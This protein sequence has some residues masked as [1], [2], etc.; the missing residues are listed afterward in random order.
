MELGR[1]E[2]IERILEGAESA[3]RSRLLESEVYGIV[4]EVG[5][6][7]PAFATVPAGAPSAEI[8]A[9]AAGLLASCRPEGLVIKIESPDILHKTEAGGLLFAPPD[10]GEAARRCAALTEA[11]LR[12]APKARLAGLL[13]CEKIPY[14]PD[15][16]GLE[17]LLSLRQDRAL[18]PVV[19]VGLGGL[20]TE[21]YGALA[22]GE[23]TWILSA[24]DP[25]LAADAPPPEGDLSPAFDLL[26][27]PSRVH[28]KAPVDLAAFWPGLRA[29]A[30]L[31]TTFGVDGQAGPFVIEEIE[32]NPMAAGAGAPVALDGLGHF[33]REKPRV[34]RRR[35]DKVRSLLEPRSVAVIGASGKAMNSGRIILRNLRAAEGVAYGRIYPVHPK[36]REID[37]VPCVPG[38]RDLPERVDL[39]VVA[40]PAEAARDAIRDL[41]D[42]EKAHS[43]ILIPGGFA[44]TGD[45]RLAGEIVEAVEKGR[46]QAD[47]GPV[48]CGG[49]CLG[50]VSKRRYNTFFLPLCKLPYHDAPGD[51]VAAI[52]QSGAYLVTLASRLDGVLFPKASISYGNQMDLTVSDF[53]EHYLDD[54]DVRILSCY[55]EG[56]QPLDGRRFIDLAREH[57]LRGR[58]VIVFKAGKTSL[59]ARAAASHTASLAGDYAAARALMENAGALVVESLDDFEDAVMAFSM[60][61]ERVPAG[62]RVAVLS[63]AGFECSVSMDA[64]F[65][66]E[67]AAFT[68][69]TKARLAE[70][71][72][73]IAHADNPIDTTPMAGT[74]AFVKAVEAMASDTGVDALVVS[75]IPVTPA[76]DSLA[77]SLDGEHGDNV[78]GERSLARELARVARATQKPVV[79]AV[80]SGRIYEDFVR[81]LLRAG[82]P[83]FRKIDRATRAL[84]LYCSARLARR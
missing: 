71:L 65:D 70:T 27:R 39:A 20:L 17:L 8:E 4:R 73:N 59:G 30:D 25:L 37:S 14:R 58:S 3:G 80:D 48:L 21:W 79:A 18:G 47:G 1:R 26:F 44:E 41:V 36:E 43:I 55:I 46:S 61:Y 77:P 2:R 15:T 32:I 84:S 78:F 69:Q 22:P 60:L 12:N 49:N 38:V 63:N 40:V 42:E 51:N 53:L 31:A 29:W 52:S 28:K 62:R 6:A 13:L 7:T 24:H 23:T 76:L 67:L 50:I 56:F 19:V 5:L 66:L 57:V 82:I 75:V 33:S 11:V 16:P 45:A 10:A 81:I 74:E 35:I 83:T 34:R 54:P 68:P 64:L 72:P 9:A